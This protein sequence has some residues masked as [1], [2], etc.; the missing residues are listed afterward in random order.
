VNGVHV[1]G[2]VSDTHK[3]SVHGMI[4]VF[5]AA[6]DSTTEVVYKDAKVWV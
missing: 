4:G 2:P 6:N 3:I 1:V 5:G